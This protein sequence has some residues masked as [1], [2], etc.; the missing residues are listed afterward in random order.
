MHRWCSLSTAR[1]SIK[2]LY[3]WNAVA[4]M[5]G[6][7]VERTQNFIVHRAL[8]SLDHTV[9]LAWASNFG[10]DTVVR[11]MGLEALSVRL[12]VDSPVG[13]DASGGRVLSQAVEAA[14]EACSNQTFAWRCL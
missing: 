6:L 12:P 9:I 2:S 7:S 1:G 13:H 14:L 8:R 10:V 3:E 5:C 4:A 11:A